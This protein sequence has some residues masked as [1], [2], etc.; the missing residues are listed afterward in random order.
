MGVLTGRE[1][2]DLEVSAS[3]HQVVMLTGVSTDQRVTLAPRPVV[4]LLLSG[5]KV[6]RPPLFLGARLE[7]VAGEEG[8][9]DVA[10]LGR[11]TRRF[12]RDTSGP[13][14]FD[15]D[16]EARILAPWAGQFRVSFRLLREEE[17]KSTSVGISGS[18]TID[19]VG[20]RDERFTTV[21]LDPVALERAIGHLTD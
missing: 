6:P 20:S 10:A 15:Q 16:G 4:R 3:G 17:G 2:T 11:R 21:A 13:V 12:T 1:G 9:A 19:I 14:A 8:A 7:P 18:D 5:A